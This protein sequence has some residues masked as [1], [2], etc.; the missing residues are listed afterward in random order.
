MTPGAAPDNVLVTQHFGSLLYVRSRHEYLPYD[1]LTTE[2]L[3]ALADRPLAALPGDLARQVP[4]RQRRAFLRLGRRLGFLA[5]DG[6]FLGR[7]VD[8]PCPDD[9]LAA[10]LTVHLA[11][12][13]RCNLDCA[14]CFAADER[15]G[16]CAELAL[17]RI[18][19]L[20]DELAGMGCQRVALTGGEPFLRR[21]LFAIIDAAEARGLDVCLTTNG[22]HLDAANVEQLARRHYAWINVSLE[23]T[24]AEVN[25][26]VRGAGHFAQVTGNLHRHC[27]GRLRFGLSVTLHRGNRHQLRG[28]PRFARRLGAEVVMLRNLYP[29]GAAAAAHDLALSFGEY[30]QAAASL[31]RGFWP[32]HVV[33]T[34]CEPFATEPEPAVVYTQFGCAAGNTVATVCANG[35]VSPCSLIGDGVALDNLRERSFASIWHAGAGFRQVRGLATPRPCAECASYDQCAGGCRARAWQ[36]TGTLGGLDPWCTHPAAPV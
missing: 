13:N 26:A 34:S 1:R 10:P 15:R 19:A 6:R 30:Q 23:G 29:I 3:R 35:D 14:H 8:R 5:A 28:L 36:A 24:T 2:V 7:I 20:F 9:H 4:P 11:V 12:T 17:P 25:D 33:P 32:T 21:D 18:E 27:K 31:A 22:C 16:P